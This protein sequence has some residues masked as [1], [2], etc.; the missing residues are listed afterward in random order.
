LG[1]TIDEL[2]HNLRPASLASEWAQNTGLSERTPGEALELAYRRHP[3]AI[4][5]CGVG[6]GVLAFTATR[7]GASPSPHGRQTVREA[8]GEMFGKLGDQVADIVRER[9]K[10]NSERLLKLAETQV[11]ST[12][13]QM[14]DAV[15]RSLQ[16]WLA[17]MPGPPAAQP[18]VTSAAQLLLATALQAVL[19]K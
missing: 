13:S 15:E 4:S 11:A 19:R 8:F 3:V 12:T 9:A 14:S 7:R 2:L 1:S 6:L 5:L 17:N 18:L 16:G 10:Q